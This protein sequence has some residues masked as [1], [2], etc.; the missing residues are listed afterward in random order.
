M[1]VDGLDVSVTMP[2]KNAAPMSTDVEIKPDAQPGRF[3][4][5]AYLGMNG[6]WEVTAKVKDKSRSGSGSFALDNHP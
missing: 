6:K 1:K 2:M 4:V 3:K 5:N